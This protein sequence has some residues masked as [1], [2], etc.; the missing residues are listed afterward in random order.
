MTVTTPFK[1]L[2]QLSKNNSQEFLENENIHPEIEYTQALK[3]LKSLKSKLNDYK[4]KEQEFIQTS[5][6]FKDYNQKME[7]LELNISNL[8]VKV[9][10]QAATYSHLL[11][12]AQDTNRFYM[13]SFV[14][15]VLVLFFYLK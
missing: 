10:E 13:L 4:D 2:K 8:K 12:Q 15:C 11:K 9:K 14:V 3:E 7:I 6:K 5:E 1:T